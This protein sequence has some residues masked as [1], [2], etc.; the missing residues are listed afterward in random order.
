MHGRGVDR[1]E[2]FKDT[3]ELSPHVMVN[4]LSTVTLVAAPSL[5]WLLSKF[6]A[7]VALH[8][9]VVLGVTI[10]ARDHTG[11]DLLR[12]NLALAHGTVACGAVVARTGMKRMA[13]ENVVR[14]LVHAHPVYFTASTMNLRQLFDTRA[15]RGYSLMADHALLGVGY[16]GTFFFGCVLVTIQARHSLRGVLFVAERQWLRRHGPRQ[17][18]LLFLI[19]ADGLRKG[20][21]C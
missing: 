12:E 15:V 7:G 4:L 20:T 9:G 10:H 11:G 5:R 17:L 2:P 19:G 14:H 3:A 1:G 8:G 18:L 16:A 21:V 6:V 13:E